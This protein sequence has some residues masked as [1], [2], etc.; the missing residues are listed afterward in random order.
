M[1]F[2][3]NHFKININCL[4]KV[5]V[6][7]QRQRAALLSNP[8][9]RNKLC[10]PQKHNELDRRVALWPCGQVRKP[11]H[12]INQRLTHSNQQLAAFQ[13]S[14]HMVG[15]S[16]TWCQDKRTEV[17]FR[18]VIEAQTKNAKFSLKINKRWKRKTTIQAWRHSAKRM[19]GW[20]RQRRDR[21]EV[22]AHSGYS[23]SFWM[24]SKPAGVKSYRN[25]NLCSRA[26]LLT[27]LLTRTGF[28]TTA[29]LN[30]NIATVM[31]LC[32]PW[33]MY[34]SGF[35]HTRVLLPINTLFWQ[36]IIPPHSFVNYWEHSCN[37]LTS[38]VFPQ[39]LVWHI[40]YCSVGSCCN[41]LSYHYPIH[42]YWSKLQEDA[43]TAGRNQG[44]RSRGEA[45]ASLHTCWTD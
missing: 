14:G 12:R 28:D 41:K 7:L 31:A 22:C 18:D 27:D 29:R 17:L 39:F 2:G 37:A 23:M 10:E 19:F 4:G 5:C 34:P 16:L 11:H 44:A 6:K 21:P 43:E 33:S 40:S 24:R 38:G 30:N 35:L 1:W 3:F 36:Q 42:Q 25:L 26:M 9:V 32:L 8:F 45:N 13:A 20:Q 15:C